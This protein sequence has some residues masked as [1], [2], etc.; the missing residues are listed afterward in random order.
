MVAVLPN[1]AF[2]QAD[3]PLPVLPEGFDFTGN[4]E[5]GGAMSNHRVHS[6]TFAGE[7]I[8]TE[9]WL[10]LSEK[11]VEPATGY[12]AKYL[13]GDDAE[14]K[15]LIEFDANNFGA[16]VYSSM[17]GWQNHILTMTSSISENGKLPYIANRFVYSV[18][19][20][21]TFIVDWQT[22]KTSSLDWVVSDHLLCKRQPRK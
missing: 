2:G 20:S 1:R 21:N 10:E 9:K 18:S 3:K 8:L 5:C 19:D 17:E 16:A 13:I 15:R 4:W 14:H 12:V 6:A 7:L 11:D 22:S